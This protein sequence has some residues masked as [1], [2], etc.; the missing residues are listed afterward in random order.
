MQRMKMYT[1]IIM[2]FA[3]ANQWIM[4]VENAKILAVETIAGKSHW[5]FMSAVLRSLTDVGHEVTVFTP[6]PEGARENYTEVDT[7]KSFPIKLEMDIEFAID[8]FGRP[9]DLMKTIIPLFRYHYCDAVYGDSHIGDILSGKINSE[10]DLII[11]EPLTYD[12]MS[13]LATVLKLPIIYVIPSPM[14]TFVERIFTGHFSN[15]ASVSHIFSHLAVPKTFAQRFISTFYFVYGQCATS[16]YDFILKKSDPKPYDNS[17]FVSPSIIFQNTHYITEAA[18]PVPPN[19]I[20][21]GGI[22]LKTAK[23]IPKVS[24]TLK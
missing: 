2:A 9:L 19:F 24:F 13:Y 18:R 4:P 7:S 5:N 3:M 12:C 16:F 1:V 21:I 10:F 17:P 6:F 11:M 22:H 23:D 8:N 20:D 14:L 15:P